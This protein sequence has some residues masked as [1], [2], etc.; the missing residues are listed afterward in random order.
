MGRQ[1]PTR[2]ARPEK[3]LRL[4]DVDDA[5]ELA[6]RYGLTP[7]EWQ[8]WVLEGWLARNAR[9]GRLASSQCGLTVPRQN[10]KNA[11][12]EIAELFKIVILGRRILHTAHEVKT[13]RK[14]FLRLA[15]F[16]ENDREWPELAEMAKEIRRTNGQ[17]AIVLHN[18]GSVEFIARSKGSGRGFTVDDLVLDEA[19]ELSED[20]LAALLPTIS[21]APSKDPQIIFTGTPPAPNMNGEVFTRVRSNALKGKN[22]RACWDEWSIPDDANLDDL[23]VIGEANP[24][25]GIRLQ[26]DVITDERTAMD[27]ETFARERGGRWNED[28]ASSALPYAAWLD[29]EDSGASR[30]SGP[31]FGLHV[32]EDRAAWFAVAWIRPSDDEVQVMLTND[33]NPVP[34]YQAA[35]EGARLSTEWSARVISTRGFVSDLQMAG[36]RVEKVD[37]ADFPAACGAFADAVKAG[38]IHH[39]NQ[40]ALNVAVKAAK[41]RPSGTTGERA[42]QL[43][44]MPEVGP[45]AAAVRAVRG[46]HVASGDV[47]SWDDVLNEEANDTEEDA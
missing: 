8:E 6:T 37:S 19:Q 41:W 20:A 7:D 14:A 32:G 16:F 30:G 45:L 1:T 44:D 38:T 3:G 9:T 40:P 12:L 25:L 46:L 47:W 34:A 28:G 36:A 27:D 5:V 31:V 17:E 2:H 22:A 39:G 42:F 4:D 26:P 35:T 24:S 21:S 11:C 15:S 13:A 33:G 43:K 18:G 23:A 29:L 10:G